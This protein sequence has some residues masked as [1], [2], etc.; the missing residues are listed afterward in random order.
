MH[1][2][3]ENKGYKK[4]KRK[5]PECHIFLGHEETLL[6]YSGCRRVNI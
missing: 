5:A 3:K 2:S 6:H 1:R 4:N